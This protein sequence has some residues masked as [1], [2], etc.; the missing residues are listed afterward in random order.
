MALPGGRHESAKGTGLLAL[1]FAC[2]VLGVRCPFGL[3][4]TGSANPQPQPRDG[5]SPAVATVTAVAAAVTA[6]MA[7]CQPRRGAVKMRRRPAEAE[8]TAEANQNKAPRVLVGGG[9]GSSGGAA[10]KKPVAR[11]TGVC[12]ECSCSGDEEDD[13]DY[14]DGVDDSSG[15]D[16]LDDFNDDN[17]DAGEDADAETAVTGPRAKSSKLWSNEQ[18][19]EGSSPLSANWDLA[20][21]KAAQ[22]WEC[23]CVDRI[24]CI[25]SERLDVLKLYEHRKSFLTTCHARGGKR[26]A[27][28]ADMSA[29]YSS[30]TRDVSRSFVVGPL[31]DCCAAS[32]AL[33]N[34]LSCQT[35]ENAR[36]DLRKERP[37]KQGRKRKK[38]SIQSY[39]RT[40]IHAYIRKLRGTWE[41]SKGK[42]KIGHWHTGKRSVP[43]RWEDYKKFRTNKKLP[44]VGSL[45]IFR[46]VWNEHDEILEAGATGHPI[47]DTCGATQSTYDRYEGRTDNAAIE[48]RAEADAKQAVH[49]SEHAG[50]REYAEDIWAKAEVGPELT[51]AM[52]MDAPTVS[53][54][55]I[56]VQKRAARDVTK[57]LEMM[58][59]WGSKVTGVMVAGWGM[60]VYLARA[61]LGSGPNLSLTL[62]YLTLMTM[63]PGELNSLGTR[64]N[65][66]MDNTGGDNKNA[67]MI[68]FIAWLVLTD[69]FEDGSFFCMLKGHTFT[70]LDQSFNTMI[71]QLLGEVIYTLT[72]LFAHIFAFMRPYGCHEVIEVHQLW[73]WSAHFKPHF[74]R[75]AGFCTGQYGSGM[76]ECYIRK[77]KHGERPAPSALPP[78]AVRYEH[79]SWLCADRCRAVLDA[80]VFKGIDMVP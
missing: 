3:H 48:A 70:I 18:F 60:M 19:P 20:N 75:M 13:D 72:A 2:C 12:N 29:H 6:T 28:R 64:Y 54:F 42:N 24:N 4:V 1:L 52:N 79:A 46:Q 10:G 65:L 36:A 69:T 11:E 30:A 35:F 8:E 63:T 56:P 58:Q 74:T 37:L 44:I 73:N 59:K 47:C 45:Y 51:T 76:H 57:R 49:D 14:D 25:G 9:G 62:L 16:G 53:Q 32:A 80:Q 23:P 17:S 61:G 78:I 50:E 26:D 22:E 34:G 38:D 66:L 5:A 67:E 77:D 43:K 27:F 31:N 68:V 21:L 7:V 15:D 55:D 33:A 71:S 40:T 39:A 41:G